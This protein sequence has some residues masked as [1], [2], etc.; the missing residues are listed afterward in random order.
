MG[1]GRGS[2]AIVLTLGVTL[3]VAAG[4]EGS[5]DLPGGG[6]PNLDGDPGRVTLHRLNRSEYNNTVRDLLGT[7]QRPADDFPFDDYGYGFDNIAD[8]LSVSPAHVELHQRAVEALIDEAMAPGGLKGTR[9]EAEDVGSDVG[10]VYQAGAWKLVSAGAITAV[11]EVATDGEYVFSVRA[12]GDQAGPDPARMTLAID[13]AETAPID[14]PVTEASPEVYDATF[15]LVAGPHTLSVAFVNDYYMPDQGLD[16][17]LVVDW[18]SLDGPVGAPQS[19]PTRDRILVCDPAA[20]DADVPGCVR[21]IARAFGRRAWR[22]PLTDDEVDSLGQ[23]ADAALAAGDDFD[24]AVSLTLEAVLLSPHFM[25]RVELDPNPGS[26]TPHAVTDHE[27]ASRLSYFLWSSMP[28]DELFELADGGALSDPAALQA[29]VARMLDDDRARAL[30]ENFAAQWLYLRGLDEHEPDYAVFPE[31]DDT[32]KQAMR[33]EAE[34]AF[35]DLLDDELTA[36]DLLTANYTYVNE[37]LAAYYGLPY[38]GQGFQ[39]VSLEGTGRSGLLTQGAILT[40]TSYPKRTSPV[41]RGKWVLEQ[42]LCSVPPPPPPGVEGLGD[43]ANQGGSLREQMEQHRTDP[44]CASCHVEM[45][46]IGFGLEHFD[47]VGAFRTAYAD[48]AIDATGALDD[49]SFDGAQQLAAVIAGDP[50]YPR[51]V[52]ERLY[53]YAL[54]RGPEDADEPYLDAIAGDFVANGYSFR[55]LIARIVASEPFRYRRGESGGGQ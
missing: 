47:A 51:C 39:R 55:A 13:G 19:N 50:R 44:I 1:S 40:V 25:Y 3:V 53:T 48:G 38:E 37:T 24:E 43:E 54:G 17:N 12:W 32:I 6:G 4:C 42:L 29:Q 27:L 10:A 11:V 45:D 36:R 49:E 33:R 16:R 7:S 31:F 23:V 41:K 14:V 20:P 30:S 5:I 46:A 21:D 34:L 52:V 18:L 22:R 9:L 15:S 2:N 26:P 35:A 8:V 28:D